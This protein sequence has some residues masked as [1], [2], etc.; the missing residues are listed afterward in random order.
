VMS[1]VLADTQSANNHQ[2]IA[3]IASS[4]LRIGVIRVASLARH[5]VQCGIAAVSLTRRRW[6]GCAWRRDGDAHLAR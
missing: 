1:G 5:G 3:H 2:V 4:S 6:S